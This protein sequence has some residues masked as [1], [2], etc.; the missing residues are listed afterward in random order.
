MPAAVTVCPHPVDTRTPRVPE[1]LTYSL[2]LP[3]ALA[4]PAVA[5]SAARTILEAHGLDDVTAAAV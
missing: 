5:R 2:T 1:N 3:S 4:S